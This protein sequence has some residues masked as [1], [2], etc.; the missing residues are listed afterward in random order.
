MAHAVTSCSAPGPRSSPQGPRLQTP[1]GLSGCF[2]LLHVS[3]PWVLGVPKFS[4]LSPPRREVPSLCQ[5][6]ITQATQPN[7]SLLQMG[8]LR[9]QQA[10]DLPPRTQVEKAVAHIF[11][12]QTQLS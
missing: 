11:G 3:A 4:G 1:S 6:S 9:L 2:L 10:G 7:P 12:F 5:A 8:K